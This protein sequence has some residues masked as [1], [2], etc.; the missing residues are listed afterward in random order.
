MNLL[1]NNCLASQLDLTWVGLLEIY[2][3]SAYAGWVCLQLQSYLSSSSF[4]SLIFLARNV[5]PPSK[6]FK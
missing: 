2:W 5:D 3:V 6:I 1:T 4:A